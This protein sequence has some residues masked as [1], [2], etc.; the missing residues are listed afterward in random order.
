[1]SVQTKKRFRNL[2][3]IV[4]IGL[5]TLLML[6]N[7]KLALLDDTEI[8]SGSISVLGIEMTL[9]DA[10]YACV[11]VEDGQWVYSKSGDIG[12][13]G[14]VWMCCETTIYPD[15]DCFLGSGC[16]WGF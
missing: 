3:K 9:F 10:T 16:G 2:G 8:A 4:G 1:M 7:I 5:F 14:S 15:T 11:G 13:G 12:P 6:T